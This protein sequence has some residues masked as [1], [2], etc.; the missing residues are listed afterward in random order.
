MAMQT[1]Q[2]E[3]RRYATKG[4]P[5][6][7]THTYAQHDDASEAK[8]QQ[9]GNSRARPDRKRRVIGLMWIHCFG[10]YFTRRR[11]EYLAAE[12]QG[13][14]SN[15]RCAERSPALRHLGIALPPAQL[16]TWPN[17][18]RRWFI[19]SPCIVFLEVMLQS[20]CRRN[21]MNHRRGWR[22]LPK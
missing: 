5:V 14:E 8:H 3:R 4:M 7:V 1:V 6:T 20:S 2:M 11:R 22:S 15:H 17:T 9:L 18:D 21:S 19:K 16:S 10:F 13:V 12:R